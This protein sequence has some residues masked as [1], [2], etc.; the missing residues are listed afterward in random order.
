MGRYAM[1]GVAIWA[2]GTAALRLAGHHLFAPDRPLTVAV[3]FAASAVAFA[4][5]TRFAFD[6]EGL[7]DAQRR[8]A[9]LALVLLP[10]L[11][12]VPSVLAAGVLFPNL[13][14]AIHATLGA[15]LMLGYWAILLGGFLPAKGGA[16]RRTAHAA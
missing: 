15:Y 14:P 7:D 4:L 3:T 16:T 11:L 5:L 9:S 2:A 1:I 12:D 13:D 8:T 6:R 10:M